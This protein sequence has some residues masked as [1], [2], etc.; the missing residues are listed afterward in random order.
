MSKT[1]K[2]V[3]YKVQVARGD[4]ARHNFGYP[5]ACF[6]AGGR[7]KV[8]RQKHE[9]HARTQLR[10][11]LAKGRDPEPVRHRHRGQWDAW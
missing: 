3:P 8:Y 7:L 4:H 10:V 1:D 6:P 11:D 5:C 2:T 9:A